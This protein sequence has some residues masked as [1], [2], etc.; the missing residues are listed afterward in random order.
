MSWAAHDLEPYLLR[1]KLGGRI[2]L[3]F[4]L[5]GS[6]SPDI[7]T[8]WAVYGLGWS[9]HEALLS[10]PVRFHRGWPGA[11]FTHTPFYGMLIAGVILLIT[12]KKLWAVSYLIGAVAH[13]LSDALDSVGIMPFWPISDWFLHV[14]LWEYGGEIGRR[15]DAVA[16]YTSLGGVWDA[17][18]AIWLLRYWRMFTVTYFRQEIVPA[19]P[20]WGWLQRWTSETVMLTVYRTSAFFGY[21]SIIGWYIWALGVNQFH[22]HL[23]WTPGGP[24]WLP[25]QGPPE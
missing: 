6:Y 9:T 8:K 7:L 2:S 11:G 25:R 22:P 16:Y 20:F 15:K 4:C 10:D 5:F 14:D 12:R 18:W 3:V 17:F 13:D 19:D 24:H 21:A 23:D 1:A